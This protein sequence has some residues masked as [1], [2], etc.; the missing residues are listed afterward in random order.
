MKH[1][2]LRDHWESDAELRR[3]ERR[4]AFVGIMSA[5][6]LLVLI[7]VAFAHAPERPDLNGWFSALKSGAKDPCCEGSDASVLKDSDWE[8]HDGHYR[9]FIEE[10]W[11]DVPD[12]AV[13]TG[14]NK[15]GRTLVWPIFYWNPPT[16]DRTGK[17]SLDRVL[18][19]CFMAG[20]L[21]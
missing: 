21:S 18:I 1:P 19:R 3:I 8:S 17:R 11:W 5:V 7:G 6:I 14:P 20:P 10:K 4:F 16:D 15:F 13:V 2:T 12:G 9:V